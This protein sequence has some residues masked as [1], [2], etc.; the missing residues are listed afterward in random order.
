MV[1]GSRKTAKS[2]GP[3][4]KPMKTA[5]R[6]NS[7]T[8][9]EAPRVP[10]SKPG[11]PTGKEKSYKSV[12]TAV[13]ETQTGS[14]E[15]Q[16]EVTE[17]RAEMTEA[18]SEMAE[19]QV[20]APENPA[21]V[22]EIPDR[23]NK[24]Q[25]GTPQAP[26]EVPEERVE[27]IEVR[28]EAADGS[29]G[30]PEVQ[31]AT[32][33]VE[34]EV[35]DGPPVSGSLPEVAS[36]IHSLDDVI[37]HLLQLEPA[38]RTELSQVHAAVARLV[39]EGSF[40]QPVKDLLIPAMGYLK[41]IFTGKAVDPAVLLEV[42]GELIGQAHRDNEA[43]EEGPS[44]AGSSAI[45]EDFSTSEE[46]VKKAHAA[47]AD[48]TGGAGQHAAPVSASP[49]TAEVRMAE[50]SATDDFDDGPDGEP[51]P[52]DADRDLMNEFIT[53]S[54]D[55]IEG[56]EA[57]LL[58]L[59]S[60]PNNQ[61]AVNSVFRA[62]HTIKGTSGFMG[63]KRVA[64]L[65]HR[66]ESLL[67]R[68]RDK[69][70]TCTGI[71][72]DLTLR[73]IDMLKELMITV[74]EALSG[75][76]M[77]RPDGYEDLLRDLAHPES[78]R[79]TAAAASPPR[80]GDILVASGKVTRETI[81]AVEKQKGEEPLGV[82]MVK[83]GAVSP[84]DLA[85]ALH[86]QKRMATESGHE[87]SLRVRTDRLDRLIDMV[88]ELVIAQ[89]MVIQDNTIHQIGNHDLLKKATHAGKIVRELQDLTMSMRMV[90][91]K[92]AFQKMA[93]LARDLAHK[94]NR[95][96][97]F[98][99][100]GEDTE[101]D[102]N[103]VDVISDPLVHMVRNAL[104]HGLEPPEERTAAGKSATGTLR[105]SAY[106]SGGDVVVEL[107]D[108]GRGLDRNRIV[109][110]ALA[111]GLI[112]ADRSFSDN[113]VFDLIFAPGFSTAEKITDISGRGVGMDVVKRSVE[114]LRGRIGIASE[115]GKGTTFVIHLPLT[116]AITDG[117]LVKVGTERYIIPTVN[118]KLSFRPDAPSLST[119][120]GRG[121]MVMLRGELMPLFR[122]HRL[123]KIAT[124]VEDPL[125]GL[126]VVVGDGNRR[127]ALL[128]D[129]LL[130]QQQVVA[131]S[132]GDGLGKIQGVSG[133]AI[134]GDG[135]VGLILDSSEIVALARHGV[136]PGN[137]DG[138]SAA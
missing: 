28:M 99:A 107:Q 93:R 68:V 30:T 59:E 136:T 19:A 17:A 49:A 51:L 74:R 73:S 81:E 124:A 98:I 1:K 83:A 32:P 127:C 41:E 100:E 45:F 92:N 76:L 111:K 121:E 128:V 4:A 97:N 23:V 135:R 94:H 71:Y 18:R 115:I 7:R 9:G 117:M 50:E 119:V 131:K 95:L 3:K 82:A 5:R 126:L 102:R 47:A 61:E 54:Q 24:D 65:A 105:L 110:K 56:A 6:T 52:Q 122:L 39:S 114:K 67:S 130:G 84:T 80:L 10:K 2:K 26:D 8:T 48:G 64:E 96:V 72:A 29:C 129:E 138:L 34:A 137:S 75:K 12:R 123:F 104:D 43:L 125:K 13:K 90:P 133:G 66:A 16:V 37:A 33:G 108:D 89:S 58:L 60:D 22:S 91:L 134:L 112:D 69:E 31:A 87:S 109:E 55:Y 53:E 25:A 116:L 57:A 78:V 120:A 85:Q 15:V 62:F 20:D 14:T 42:A 35:S 118:I 21:A 44:P 88:G 38:D 36:H 70:I 77:M 27:T 132:L 79:G 113:E 106:H 86:T 103:M 46:D 101:I 11:M 63:L 40:A